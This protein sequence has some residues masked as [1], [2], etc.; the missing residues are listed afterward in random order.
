MR[1]HHARMTT[2]HPPR[3][4]AAPMRTS[5]RCEIRVRGLLGPTFLQAFPTLRSCRRGRDTLLTGAV[6]DQAELFGV[7]H[8]IE[9]LGLEL[10]ELRVLGERESHEPGEDASSDPLRRSGPHTPPR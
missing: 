10:L 3:D 5:R 7:L 4:D 8:G 9:A 2:T 6:E 1:N